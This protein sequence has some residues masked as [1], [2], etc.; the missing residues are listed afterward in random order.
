[1]AAVLGIAVLVLAACAGSRERQLPADRSAPVLY[2][3]LGDSTVEGIGASRPELNYV[4]RLHDRL[5]AVYPAAQVRNL[6]VGGATSADVLAG[7][8][9]RAVGLGPQLV[10]LSIGPND[11]TR[12]VPP[13]AY[14]RNLD[15]ILARLTRETEAVVVV[16]LLP[17]LGVTPRFRGQPQQALVT[18]R[19]EELNDIIRRKGREYRAAL[20]DLHGP[21]R[22]EVPRRPEL[23]AADGYH[24]SDVGYARWAELMWR[25]VEPRV[26]R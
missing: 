9:A 12:A 19:T 6:G 5:R 25:G 14:E 13:S 7:Q 20:V 3:A 21:S 10:T 26:V 22:D 1:M 4:S 23:V 24:P 11:I 8:L 15:A 16:N 2:I 17:D 18:R